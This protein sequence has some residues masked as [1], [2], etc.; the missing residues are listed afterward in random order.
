MDALYQSVEKLDVIIR[1]INEVLDYKNLVNDKREIVSFA[2]IVSD[3]ETSIK[4]IQKIDEFQISAD[5]SEISEILTLKSYL[6]SIFF[7]IISN[8]IKFRQ[9]D[10]KPVIQITTKRSGKT[11]A[12]IFEDNGLGFDVNSNRANVFG[13]Y[14]RFHNH[15]EGKGIGLYMVKTQVEALGGRIGIHSTVNKGTTIKIE[16]E[17]N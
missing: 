13:L 8:A 2:D 14:K 17:I 9:P 4:N 12:I 6:H 15:I 10:V 16:F 7:N 3:I 5:F 11:A 1:D